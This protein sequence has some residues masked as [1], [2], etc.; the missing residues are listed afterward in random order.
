MQTLTSFMSYWQNNR[1]L[2]RYV[3]VSKISSLTSLRPSVNIF[4]FITCQCSCSSF[5][6][7]VPFAVV[8]VL[9][10]RWVVLRVWWVWLADTYIPVGPFVQ[11][12]DGLVT[13]NV[14][15][16]TTCVRIKL[17]E[18]SSPLKSQFSVT[19]P[20]GSWNS[21]RRSNGTVGLWLYWDRI[22]AV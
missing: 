6:I 14:L 8:R 3:Y 5:R 10:C 7:L 2:S 15:C 22:S 20:K 21:E 9:G 17:L 12:I 13:H 1:S 16:V 11:V 19:A 18:V 4:I